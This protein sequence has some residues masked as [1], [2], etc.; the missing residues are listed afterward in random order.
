MRR[1]AIQGPLTADMTQV[2]DL[3]ASLAAYGRAAA[4]PSPAPT[5]S[6]PPSPTPVSRSPTPETA[7]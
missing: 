7:R 1:S 2:A 6:G 5:A 4:A 3:V